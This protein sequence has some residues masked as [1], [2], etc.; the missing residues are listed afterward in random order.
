MQSRT[1]AGQLAAF[2]A[3]A[4]RWM[5][6]R[7]PSAAGGASRTHLWLHRGRRRPAEPPDR[8]G[9]PRG[10]LARADGRHAAARG[11]SRACARR[12]DSL[13]RLLHWRRLDGQ[14]D[15]LLSAEQQQPKHAFNL[16][17]LS[18]TLGRRELAELL[19]LAQHQ[20]HVLV[21]R[22]E[23][24]DELPAIGDRHAH[25]PV[26]VLQHLGALR[27]H[28]GGGQRRRGRRCYCR[29]CCCRC[30]SC[31]GG[32]GSAPVSMRARPSRGVARARAVCLRGRPA[33][34]GAGRRPP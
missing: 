15:D 24:A 28:H 9:E 25:A 1:R 21:E 3:A 18:R 31:G 30:C 14:R 13:L 4:R 19:S 34:V 32:G 12:N 10:R 7:R 20:V 16:P 17:R 6:T 29:C 22:H 23:L 2:G 26:D 8:A 27:E 5:R 33:P 11:L